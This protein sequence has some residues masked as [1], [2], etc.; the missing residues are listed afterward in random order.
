MDPD[1]FPSIDS[2]IFP[3][4][5]PNIF[6]SMDP[7]I[8]PSLDPDIFPSMDPDIFFKFAIS[9]SNCCFKHTYKRYVKMKLGII[10][11]HM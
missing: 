7:D 6:P 3:S 9:I 10:F 1:I 2:D 4:M 5:D 8:F 11:C